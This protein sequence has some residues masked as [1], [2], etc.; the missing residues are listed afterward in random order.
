MRTVTNQVNDINRRRRLVTPNHRLSN[1]HMHRNKNMTTAS[2]L[3]QHMRQ[4][5]PARNTAKH[6]SRPHI[7]HR[8]SQLTD[9]PSPDVP[10]PDVPSPGTIINSLHSSRINIHNNIRI[11]LD[12]RNDRPKSRR[13]RILNQYSPY[14]AIKYQQEIENTRRT[15]RITRTSQQP[16]PRNIHRHNRHI[17]KPN[18]SKDLQVV[19]NR[20]YARNHHH[21]IAI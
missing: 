14:H 10:S 8:Q 18:R 17:H 3:E 5:G 21:I 4:A 11:N 6:K 16:P 1:S 15:S 2:V 20:P 7:A 12:I 13:I 9:V 19:T